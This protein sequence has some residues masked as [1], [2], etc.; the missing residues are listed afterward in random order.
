V[1]TELKRLVIGMHDYGSGLDLTRFEVTADFTLDGVPAGENLASKFK[2]KTQGVW[3]WTLAKPLTKL[4]RGKLTISV[5]DRQG[6]VTKIER[7]FSIRE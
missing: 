6:N 2:T 7:S 5:A 4:E 1:N 3:E